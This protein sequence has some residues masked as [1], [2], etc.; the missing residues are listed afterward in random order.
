MFDNMTLRE[1]EDTSRSKIEAS[2]NLHTLLPNLDF[3]ILLSSISGVVGNPGQSNYAA[4]CTFQDA[5]ARQRNEQ[6]QKA[7]S[8]DLGVMRSIGVVA[9]SERLQQHFQGS[10]GFVPI[11]E[12]E[13]VS[14]LDICCDPSYQPAAHQSQM[15]MGL[16]TPASLLARSLEPPEMLQRPLFARFSQ[17]PGR[18]GGGGSGDGDVDAA[19][20]FRQL[21]SPAER[22][23]VVVDALSKRLARTLSIKLEDVDTHQALHAYGVD[24]LIAVELRSWLGKEF[25]ADVPV[26]EIV[27]GKTVEAIGELVARTT[28]IEGKV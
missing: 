13:F 6:G 8:I 14:L 23:Q 9:E 4:G 22:A 1:W 24:S 18:S 27:S 11:E 20:L 26:F 5:L 25:A 28:R 2:W 19:R 17:L 16:E 15:V 10:K 12:S 7:I 3:F 21:Q